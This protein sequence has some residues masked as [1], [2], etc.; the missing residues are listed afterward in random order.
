MGIENV[1]KRILRFLGK[2][3]P[4]GPDW[5]TRLLGWF[6]DEP[7]SDLPVLVSEEL[8]NRLKPFLRFRHLVTHGYAL[9]LEWN[10]MREGLEE[11]RPVFEAFRTRVEDYLDSLDVSD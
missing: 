1:F 3:P 11:A 10:R 6:G 5:H 2:E 9:D 4:S 8:A 7:R